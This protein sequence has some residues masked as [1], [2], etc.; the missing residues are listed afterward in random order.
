MHVKIVSA[1]QA[2]PH[3]Y[4]AHDMRTAKMIREMVQNEGFK[5][6]RIVRCSPEEY[7]TYWKREYRKHNW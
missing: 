7:E 5:R 2:E 3:A 4:I 1:S 6:V